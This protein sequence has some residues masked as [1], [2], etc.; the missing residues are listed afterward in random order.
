MTRA[1]REVVELYNLVVWNKRDLAL[2]EEPCS[3]SREAGTVWGALPTSPTRTGAST[4]SV[5][6]R[7][8]RSRLGP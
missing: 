4:T 7:C 1:A 5:Q 2:A 6:P 3:G 8:R